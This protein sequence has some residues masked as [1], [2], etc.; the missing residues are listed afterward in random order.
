MNISISWRGRGGGEE[1]EGGERREEWRRRKEREGGGGRGRER[2]GEG[3]RGRE[4]EGG[5][6]GLGAH[7]SLC[8]LRACYCLTLPG[9]VVGKGQW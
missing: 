1:E 3:G 2:E 5:N 9:V 7:Q 6:Q 4:S 8:Q